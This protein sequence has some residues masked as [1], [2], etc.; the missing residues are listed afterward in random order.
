MS[1]NNFFEEHF[2]QVDYGAEELR[3]TLFESCV[4]KNCSFAQLNFIG[5]TFEDYE[6]INCDFTGA[7]INESAFR[8]VSFVGCKMIGLNFESVNPFRL[9]I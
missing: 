9:K 3:K 2:K 4:L 7:F 8:E 5:L 6:F 1:E